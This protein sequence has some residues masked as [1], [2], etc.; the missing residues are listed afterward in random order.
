VADKFVWYQI[1]ELGQFF[2]QFTYS[3]LWWWYIYGDEFW[4]YLPR[5]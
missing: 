2:K 4:T 5:W 3:C 1:I